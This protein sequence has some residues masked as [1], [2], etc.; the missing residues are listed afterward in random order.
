[1]ERFLAQLIAYTVGLV[2]VLVLGSIGFLQQ[3]QALGLGLVWA[4]AALPFVSFAIYLS[5]D[6]AFDGMNWLLGLSFAYCRTLVSR[7]IA[8]GEASEISSPQCPHR[9]GI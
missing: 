1:V 6:K 5:Y 8:Q 4:I 2:V 7:H 9:Q 3:I